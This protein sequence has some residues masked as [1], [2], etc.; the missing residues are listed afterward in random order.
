[1]RAAVD[2]T[3]ATA[4]HRVEVRALV[5]LCAVA[6]A[7]AAAPPALAASPVVVEDDAGDNGEAPDIVRVEASRVPGAVVF[8]VRFA[9]SPTLARDVELVTILVDADRDE[10]TGPEGTELALRAD[11]EGVRLEAWEDAL[12]QEVAGAPARAS[13]ADSVLT[14]TLGRAALRGSRTFDFVVVASEGDL[15]LEGTSDYA[16]DVEPA[17]FALP[18]IARVIADVGAA[19]TGHR[20]TAAVAVVL[21]DGSR[22][23]PTTLACTARLRGRVLARSGRCAW[24]LPAATS[25]ATLVV[26]LVATWEGAAAR[27]VARR[28]RVR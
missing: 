15:D 25:G 20:V 22:E 8:A 28:L 13:Y 19:R 23:P 21:S 10:T 7:L 11:A 24:R 26:T 5:V 17:S 18:G 1:M 12:W 6:S 27:P 16:P 4:D 2:E 14:V 9:G 3:L